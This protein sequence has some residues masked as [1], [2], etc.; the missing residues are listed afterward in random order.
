[1]PYYETNWIPSAE[2]NASPK[3]PQERTWLAIAV[4]LLLPLLVV[5]VLG[6][7]WSGNGNPKS[8]LVLITTEEGGSG[9]GILIHSDGVIITERRV[10]M[11]N[12]QPAREIDVHITNGAGKRQTYRAEILSTQNQKA[13]PNNASPLQDLPQNYAL[14]K[15]QGKGFPYITI[16][17]SAQLTQNAPVTAMGFPY[18]NQLSSNDVAP[19]LSVHSG[20]LT[21]LFPTTDAP[22]ALFHNCKTDRG[23]EGG[24]LMDARGRLVGILAGNS[25]E[26]KD[27]PKPVAIPTQSLQSI[28]QQ[29]AQSRATGRF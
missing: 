23:N 25:T 3:A 15:I 27:T 24:A 12:S 29:Y 14:I 10:V 19:T 22:T 2:T 21:R 16:G 6:F 5:W 17:D 20:T 26:P 9:T 13:S 1:M 7:F 18:V 28:W 8:A 11:T 4:A